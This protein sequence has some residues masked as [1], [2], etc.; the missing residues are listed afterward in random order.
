MIS[1]YTLPR[2]GKIWKEEE[3]L[4]LW[5]KIEILVCQAWAELGKIPQEAVKKIEKDAAFDINRIKKI[6]EKVVYGT[7]ILKTI[8]KES[9]DYDL[10]LIG[11]SK[12]N[13]WR[14]IRFGTIPEKLTRRSK[15]SV[16]VVRKYDGMI[17]SWLRRFLA[18]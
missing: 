13:L 3:K 18:G 1:R 12:V 9:E 16:L 5:L 10:V 7:N 14:R 15:V 2:M 8:L 6:E 4:G 17:R 11:A